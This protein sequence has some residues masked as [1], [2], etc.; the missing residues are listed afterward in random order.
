ME[1]NEKHSGGD[2]NMWYIEKVNL[3]SIF[4]PHKFADF[5]E[6]HQFKNYKKGE[7]IYFTDDPSNSIYLLVE[8]K[9][10][11]LYYTDEGS[12]VIKSVLTSGDVFGEL[13]ILGEEKRKDFAIVVQDNTS[14]CQLTIDQMQE[15]MKKNLNFAL[16]INKLIG[17]R[18]RKLERRVDSLVFKDVRTRML[19]FIREF[20]EEKG[21]EKGESYQINHFLTHKDM[22]DLIGTT[23]QTVTTLLN[24]MKSEGLIDF[25]R[26]SIYVP[27]IKALS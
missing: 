12:E 3:F 18:I 24:E 21:E 22:A 20:A 26:R 11:I 8:G 5:K 17:L 14:I 6:E 19:E 4:C 2:G 13:S 10:K 25:G 9:V 1:L 7:F 15:L 27:N 23:R 16:K